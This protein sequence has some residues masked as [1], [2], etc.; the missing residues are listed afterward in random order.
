[1]WRPLFSCVSSSNDKAQQNKGHRLGD[2]T[3]LST[4]AVSVVDTV[5]II[6]TAANRPS[7]R[8]TRPI[9]LVPPRMIGLAA[10]RILD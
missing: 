2:E 10:R 3:A 7:C 9:I 6:V 1:M 5:I 4:M 8:E